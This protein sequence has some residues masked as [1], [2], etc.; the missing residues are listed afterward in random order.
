MPHAPLSFCPT[1]GLCRGYEEHARERRRQIDAERDPSHA[2][3]FKNARWRRYRRY[4]LEAHPLCSRC[5]HEGLVVVGSIVDHILP[6]R[7]DLT[8]FWAE[9]NVQ[10]MCPSHDAAKRLRENELGPCLDHGRWSA[11]VLGSLVC[12]DCGHSAV[13]AY[14]PIHALR[15]DLP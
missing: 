8:L 12:R 10:T 6:H 11:I 3:L 2:A 1:H 15:E 7:G 13:T 4:Y 14:I 5:E 9:G